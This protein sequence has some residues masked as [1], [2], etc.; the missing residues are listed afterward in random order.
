MTYGQFEEQYKP[1]KN[2][3]VQ[4]SSYNGCMFETYGI[5][6]AHVREQNNEKIWTLIEGDNEDWYIIPGLHFVNRFG[7]FICENE[8][9]DEEIEVDDN[10]HLSKDEAIKHCFEF[11]KQNGLGLHIEVIKGFYPKENYTTGEAKYIA[12]DVYEEITGTDLTGKQED[13]IHNYYSQL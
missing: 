5:E 8:W 4:D 10:E 11:W 3:F 13:E 12:I 7:Y 1:I 9:E 2:P 6:V